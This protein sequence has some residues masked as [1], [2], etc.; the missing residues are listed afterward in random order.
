MSQTF[1]AIVRY[2]GTDFAGWQIQPNERTIQGEIERALSTIAQTPI[3]IKG[4]GRTDAG[5]HA[6][7]QVFSCKW[8]IPLESEQVRR[9]LSKMLSPGIRIESV[10]P[11]SDDFDARYSARAKRYHYTFNLS[12]EPDPLAARYAW[13]VPPETD[14]DLIRRLSHQ[15]IGEHDFAGFQCVGTPIEN[16]IR[17][18][19]EVTLNQGPVI[20]PTDSRAVWNL[21]FHGNG[22]LYKMVRNLS[23]TLIEIGYGRLDPAELERRLTDPGPYRGYTA[24]AHGLCLVEVI[25]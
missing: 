24:P 14:L 23:A 17:T 13:N 25:Y 18:I 7:A 8:P 10:E 15:L 12:A 19:Y 5:V 2:D 21:G 3:R 6:L 9:S 16:T 22:F 1:K 11:V 20:G 4:A